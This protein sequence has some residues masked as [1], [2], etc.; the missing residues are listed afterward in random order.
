MEDVSQGLQF[1]SDEA[2]THSTLATLL[3]RIRLR[4]SLASGFS[5]FSLGSKCGKIKQNTYIKNKAKLN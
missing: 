1:W 4:A 3:L 2:S 5:L